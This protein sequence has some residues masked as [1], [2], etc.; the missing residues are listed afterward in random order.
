MVRGIEDKHTF[1]SLGTGEAE[2]GEFLIDSVVPEE[3]G[4][5]SS[6]ETA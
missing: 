5:M 4:I 2:I 3:A 6:I 1:I